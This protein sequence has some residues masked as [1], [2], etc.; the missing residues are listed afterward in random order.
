[1]SDIK[2]DEKTMDNL[3][4][5]SKLKLT[6]NE[7]NRAISEL[8]RMLSYVD[9]LNELDTEDKEPLIHAIPQVNIF[10]ED[11]VENCDGTEA[12]LSNAPKVKDNQIIVP[13]TI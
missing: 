3:E 1:M 5:L 4:I 2:I 10:R 12:T 11:V 13:K 8:E 7:R 9:K 6:E